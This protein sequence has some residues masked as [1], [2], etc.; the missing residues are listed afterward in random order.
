MDSTINLDSK[1]LRCWWHLEPESPTMYTRVTKGPSRNGRLFGGLQNTLDQACRTNTSWPAGSIVQD[2]W[3]GCKVCF[4]NPFVL[5][6]ED[7]SGLGELRNPSPDSKA[8]FG[9][10][11]PSEAGESPCSGNDLV[12]TS[13]RN[14]PESRQYRCVLGLGQGSLERRSER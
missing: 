13:S 2:L 1:L 3:D 10:L 5:S 12:K 8:P 4:T 7:L 11:D 14:G 6:H 9:D